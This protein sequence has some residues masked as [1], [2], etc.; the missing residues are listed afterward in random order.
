MMQGI[1]PL[2]QN[3]LCSDDVP[4]H[5]PERI[6]YWSFDEAMSLTTAEQCH[7]SPFPRDVLS[8][9][10]RNLITYSREE[11]GDKINWRFK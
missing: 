11:K 5:K 9:G 1:L 10:N 8:L 4:K 2:P 7:T 6:E 3:E